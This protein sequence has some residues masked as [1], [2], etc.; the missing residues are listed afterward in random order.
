MT[1]I[2]VAHVIATLIGATV[3]VLWT[4]LILAIE[5]RA[6]AKAAL[7]DVALML[8][9]ASAYQ[10][11]DALGRSFTVFVAEAVGSAAMTWWTVKRAQ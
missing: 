5:A 3:A 4:R 10:L 8:I 2:F 6:A 9:G 11:W 1:N 7:L